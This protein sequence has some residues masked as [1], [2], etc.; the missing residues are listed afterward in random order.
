MA[1][2]LNP[3]VELLALE[4]RWSVLICTRCR[5]AL[6]PG[7]V[8]AHL[9]SHHSSTITS[10]QAKSYADTWKAVPLQ[11]PKLVQQ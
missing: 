5:Y 7:A 9:R 11:S 8:V 6:V 2:L 4:P 3:T 10:T 1:S